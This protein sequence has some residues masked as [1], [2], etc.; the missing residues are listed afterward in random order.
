MR[1]GVSLLNLTVDGAEAGY[2]NGRFAGVAYWNADGLVADCRITGVSLV[3]VTEQ[4]SGVGIYAGNDDRGPYELS[5]LQTAIDG[6]QA[7][8]M[9]FT[10]RGLS[11]AVSSCTVE[12]RGA[13]SEIG[14]TGIQIID[15]PFGKISDCHV[16]GHD[17][18]GSGGRVG[19]GIWVENAGGPVELGYGC[20]SVNDQV[21]V[22]FLNSD[23]A[24]RETVIAN[25]GDSKS[26]IELRNTRVAPAI[27]GGMQPMGEDR[28]ETESHPMHVEVSGCD[29]GGH[30]VTGIGIVTDGG[31][32][33]ADLA[34]NKIHNWETGVIVEGRER[35]VVHAY[36]NRF[37]ENTYSHAVDNSA[38]PPS[39]WDLVAGGGPGNYWGDYS[40][41]GVYAIAGTAGAIDHSPNPS[42]AFGLTSVS[43]LLNCGE[44][45]TLAVT[46]DPVACM[47]G[48]DLLF[49]FDP[50]R[51]NSPTFTNVLPLDAL[52]EVQ[53]DFTAYA[54][55]SGKWRISHTIVG[56][57][58]GFSCATPTEIC[59]ISL[60]P[61]AGAPQGSSSFGLATRY[62]SVDYPAVHDTFSEDIDAVIHASRPGVSVDCSPPTVTGVTASG[63]VRDGGVPAVIVNGQETPPSGGHVTKLW[64]Q[65]QPQGHAM[66]QR[67]FELER[68]RRRVA[69]LGKLG[70]RARLPGNDRSRLH[71]AV[72]DVR[73]GG[74]RSRQ[75][76]IL[77]RRGEHQLHL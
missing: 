51:W 11:L 3:P 55:A 65:F 72:Q 12:G 32:I 50:T 7:N 57:T 52:G 67:P 47:R 17:Y 18:V 23:G 43:S 21:G 33:E 39:T 4:Y 2:G 71:R 75:Q 9:L 54:V 74:R 41:A 59:L 6:Y 34:G 1:G 76:G 20:T 63:V 77:R 35:T 53:S 46:I 30:G 10:G 48:Y 37:Y 61:R 40:G 16:S 44:S 36:G 42:T 31:R 45:A 68:A 66:Q 26:G 69:V 28:H 8:G 49:E 24:I 56:Q 15:G 29:V 14:Q 5:V 27:P 13:M 62:A 38:S 73:H 58:S 22:L 70:H 64:Y 25:V 60:T 19:T